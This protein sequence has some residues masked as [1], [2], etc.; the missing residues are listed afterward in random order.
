[1]I[2]KGIAFLVVFSI[3]F[4]TVQ[5]VIAYKWERSEHL[6]GR[7]EEWRNAEKDSIDVLYIGSSPMYAGINP[8]VIYHETG[9]TGYNFGTSNQVA[10]FEYYMFE[11]LMKFHTPKLVVIE[12]NHLCDERDVDGDSELN[13]QL[14]RKVVN[15][16]PDNGIKK[17]MLDV[18]HQRYPGQ[19]ILSYWL[20][21]LRYHSRWNQLDPYDFDQD[22]SRLTDNYDPCNKGALFRSLIKEQTWKKS[23]YVG[24]SAEPIDFYMDYYQRIVDECK[25]KNI[26]VMTLTI[27]KL[28]TRKCDHE[29][30]Q[31]FAEKNGLVYKYYNTKAEWDAIGLDVKKDF[32]NAGH[33]NILGQQKYSK[34]LGKFIQDTYHL[35]D[36]RTDEKYKS[37]EEDYQEYLKRYEDAKKELLK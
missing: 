2:M 10:F 4:F 21:L 34:V 11:Y 5:N 36:H 7:Y 25:A 24:D 1:M 13:E 32:Y 22:N 20:P 37:W 16:M 6:A 33:M 23:Y 8:S 30:A 28:D 14:F 26:E 31:A 29:A 35:E 18:I 12:M 3:V 9:M 27:P 19:D 15:T 17:E